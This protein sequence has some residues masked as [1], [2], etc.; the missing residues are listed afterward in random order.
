M[1]VTVL[2]AG[3]DPQA[4]TIYDGLFK[5]FDT[6]RSLGN[7]NLMGWLIDAKENGSGTYS[8]ATDGDLDIAYSLL[9]AH[10]QWGSEGAIAYL[11]EAKKIINQGLKDSN[12]TA[13]KRTNL[14][15]WALDDPKKKQATRPSD[16][17][18]AHFRAVS[19]GNKRSALESSR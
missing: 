14:G 16:W 10:E 19:S 3:Y 6:H 8:S 2:M 7:P 5:M 12:I 1:I 4:K 11:E 15:D 18:T 9:L 17:M 13:S